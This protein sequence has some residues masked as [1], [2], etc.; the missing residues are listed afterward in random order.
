MY[1]RSQKCW[2]IR[3]K[4]PDARRMSAALLCGMQA[5]ATQQMGLF[6]RI[7][8]RWGIFRYTPRPLFSTKPEEKEEN[9]SPCPLPGKAQPPGAESSPLFTPSFQHSTFLFHRAGGKEN[10]Q[11]RFHKLS[12]KA[13]HPGGKAKPL[14]GK[15]KS[16]FSTQSPAPTTFTA[17]SINRETAPPALF[18]TKPY[19]DPTGPS[20]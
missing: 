16:G 17:T 20:Q 3:Q 9:P 6:G 2:D 4:A 11:T 10:G 18:R 13:S 12:T 5:N 14:S 7:E 15:G 19:R 1:L 8:Q